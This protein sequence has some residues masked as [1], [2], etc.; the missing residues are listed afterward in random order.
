MIRWTL[1]LL[2]LPFVFACQSAPEEIP[3]DLS[4]PEFFQRAQDEFDAENWD[5]AIRYYETFVER[6]PDAV[7]AHVEARYEIALIAYRRGNPAEA[8]EMFE[9]LLA[10]YDASEV[11]LPEWPRVLAQILIEEIDEASRPA[12]TEAE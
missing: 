9:A 8:R 12:E 4:Q 3:Q 5:N 2:I 6:F 7:G 11:A 1:L 10:E